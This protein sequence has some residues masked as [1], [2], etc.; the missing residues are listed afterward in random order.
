MSTQS[1][2]ESTTTQANDLQQTYT[3]ILIPQDYEVQSI[4]DK[5]IKVVLEPFERGFGHTLGFA[6]RRI[7]L[8]S[9]LGFAITKVKIDG[10]T[11]Q[12]DTI[13]GIQEDVLE[14]LMNIKSVALKSTQSESINISLEVTGPKVVT[15]ADFIVEGNKAEIINPDHVICHINT[16][17]TFRMTLLAESGK[18]YTNA[19]ELADRD[20][21]NGQQVGTL[22]IDA[23]FSPVNRVVYH[24]ENARVENRTDL[25]KLILEIETDGT[26][27]AD[28]AIRRAATILQ[29]QLSPFAELKT[30]TED[31]DTYMD[32]N[33]DPVFSRLVD[34]LELTVRA[35]NCLKSENVRYIGELVQ[36][37]EYDLLRTPNLG[38]KSLSEIKCVL[39]E[40]GFTLGMQLPNWVSPS[41]QRKRLRKEPRDTERNEV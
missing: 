40:L 20:S 22:Y 36:C 33:I 19:N 5:N 35:A 26:L 21:V 7:L 23:S 4:D 39:A 2:S 34:E 38:R 12:Y 37:T 24:V 29:Y 31:E 3:N 27:T 15:A 11:H 8:S 25:D 13:A 32:D 30:K 41:D 18:G 6:L 16:D 1:Q 10:I 17:K 9:M 14:I 28:D